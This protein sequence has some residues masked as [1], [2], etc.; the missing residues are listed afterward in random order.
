MLMEQQNDSSSPSQASLTMRMVAGA[1]IGLFLI[2]LYLLTVVEPD[3]VWGKFWMLRP[4]AFMVFAGATGGLCNHLVMQYHRQF[5]IGKTLALV[6]RALVFIAGLFMGF[7]L[8]LDG[9]LW[10]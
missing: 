2:S 7:V 4:L 9:T 6:V 5:G 3:P 8:G 1:G 10:H